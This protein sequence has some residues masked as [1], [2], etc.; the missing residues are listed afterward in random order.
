MLGKLIPHPSSTNFDDDVDGQPPQ[1]RPKRF[2]SS[3]TVDSQD[4]QNGEIPL[5]D[6][7]TLQPREIPDS[8]EEDGGDDDSDERPPPGT[9]GRLTELET[10]LPSVKTDKQA[11]AD[12]E[13]HKAEADARSNL[14]RE[15][16]LDQR[17]W[18]KGKSSIYVDAFNLALETVL[19]D[20][21]H[22]FDEAEVAVFESWRA[23]DYEAQYL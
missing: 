2:E 9:S 5:N 23:L 6:S 16:R 21:A 1:K 3:D 20:E 19:E 15:G 4:V 14:A 12:Y 22:L 13:A 18:T 17:K 10:A 11:I 8:E 7:P